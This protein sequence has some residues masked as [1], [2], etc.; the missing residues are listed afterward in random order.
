MQE[1]GHD[2]ADT[3]DCNYCWLYTRAALQRGKLPMKGY[4]GEKSNFFRCGARKSNGKEK[5]IFYLSNR[6]KMIGKFFVFLIKSTFNRALFLNAMR[7]CS[8]DS[9]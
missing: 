6:S 3:E 7:V 5:V 9:T 2:I 8:T 4:I 1:S